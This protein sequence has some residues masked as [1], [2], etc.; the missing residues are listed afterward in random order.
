[1]KGETRNLEERFTSNCCYLAG[2]SYIPE[3]DTCTS[4]LQTGKRFGSPPR[5][6]W[7]EQWKTASAPLLCGRWSVSNQPGT[8]QL[9]LQLHHHVNSDAQ[10]VS[11]YQWP[12]TPYCWWSQERPRTLSP[13]TTWWSQMKQKDTQGGQLKKSTKDSMKNAHTVH[14]SSKG[15]NRDYYLSHPHLTL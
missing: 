1:M 15:P 14:V 6:H 7:S 13:L 10:P 12:F 4:Q 2:S 5:P 8:C 9:L 11:R 3:C